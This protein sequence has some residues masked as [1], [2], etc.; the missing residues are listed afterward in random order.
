MFTDRH[1]AYCWWT[2]P[3]QKLTPAHLLSPA[4]LLPCW[5]GRGT[6]ITLDGT[7]E[8]RAAWNNWDIQTPSCPR[9][10]MLTWVCGQGDSGQGRTSC[11]QLSRA[12]SGEWRLESGEYD[13]LSPSV[14]WM[15]IYKH[16]AAAGPRSRSQQNA[17]NISVF[18]SLVVRPGDTDIVQPGLPGVT[19]F[20]PAATCNRCNLSNIFLLSP[21]ED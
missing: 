5:Q 17:G 8:L 3:A 7:L 2:D 16:P 9:L 1:T 21:S 12:E 13:S 14:N 11:P 4:A 18:I 19:S 15:S 6:L 20:Q 10:Q